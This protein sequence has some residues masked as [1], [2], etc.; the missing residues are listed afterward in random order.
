[1]SEVKVREVQP[2]QRSDGM[3]KQVEEGISGWKKSKTGIQTASV[4]HSRFLCIFRT[5]IVFS[6]LS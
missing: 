5:L 4:R 3:K 2:D 1:M 6:L